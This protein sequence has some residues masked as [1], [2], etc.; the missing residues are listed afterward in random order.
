MRHARMVASNER[1]DGFE[2]VDEAMLEQEIKRT[3]N[4]GRSRNAGT[5][6]QPIEQVIGLDRN[7]RFSDE[8]EDAQPNRSQTQSPLIAD[9]CNIAHEGI[10]IVAMRVV[11]IGFPSCRGHG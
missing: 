8:F 2:F 10:G 1:I 3:V 11:C 4:R 5:I 7:G 9:L 6:L